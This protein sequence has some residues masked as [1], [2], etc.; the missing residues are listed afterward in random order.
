[1]KPKQKKQ[2]CIWNL[3]ETKAVWSELMVKKP[4]WKRPLSIPE[5]KQPQRIHAS[6]PTIELH[7]CLK[8]YMEPSRR[9]IGP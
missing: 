2:K 6:T 4:M 8:M 9:Q 7:M 1:M 3:G 5:P